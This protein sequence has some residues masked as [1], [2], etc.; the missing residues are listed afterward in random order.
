MGDGVGT[1]R[2]AESSFDARSNEIFREDLERLEVLAHPLRLKLLRLASRGDVSAK[3]AS[4][5]LDEPIAKVSYHVRV[6]AD[7]GLIE[8]V[9]QTPRRGAI[10]THYRAAVLLDFDDETLAAMSVEQRLKLTVAALQDWSADM[11]RAVEVGGFELD[12]ALAI[13]AHFEADAQG[14]A[15]IRRA[16]D[17]HYE[18]LLEIEAEITERRRLAPPTETTEVNTMAALYGA[19]RM[20]AANGPFLLRRRG[21]N[22]PLIPED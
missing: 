4:A 8:L 21:R 12:D 18:R 16:I 13:N 6:L 7:A 20:P 2:G 17:D 19:Q 5:A 3:E 15:D 9:R 22:M 1:V 10:E 11:L 14:V